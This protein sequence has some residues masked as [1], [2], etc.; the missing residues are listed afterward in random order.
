[1]NDDQSD[2][3]IACSLRPGDFHDRREVWE[4]LAVRALRESRPT[5]NGVRFFYAASEE[6]ERALRE[7]ARLEAE[8]CAFAEWRLDRR[9]EELVLD[10]TS[11]T[12]G[13]AAIRTLFGVG[14]SRPPS[15][16]DSP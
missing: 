4:R 15:G 10:V 12:E 11:T 14:P 6:T 2:V 16:G 9:G 8:C 3:A 5:D 1:M 7:L 13:A